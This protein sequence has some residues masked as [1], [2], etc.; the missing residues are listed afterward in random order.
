MTDAPK[1]YTPAEAAKE[2][3]ISRTWVYQLC[4][5]GELSTIRLHTYGRIRIPAEELQRVRKPQKK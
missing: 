1:T 2:L 3:G 4:Q 5:R